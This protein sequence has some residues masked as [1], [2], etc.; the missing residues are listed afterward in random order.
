MKKLIMALAVALTFGFATAGSV[1]Q[2]SVVENEIT[3]INLPFGIKGYSP[4]NKDVVRIEASSDTSLRITALKRGR[5]DLE[6]RGD[7]D[8]V[9]K[10]EIT[11]LGDLATELETLT[12]ELDQVQ[13]VRARIVGNSIRVDGEISSISKW[14]YL[15]KVLRNYGTSVR[16]FVTFLP[17]PEVLLRMKETLQ[18]AGF[19]VV[20]QP[21]GNDRKTWKAK[22][23]ALALNKQTRIMTVQGKVYTPEQRALVLQC[24][25]S[26][27]W[28]SL[29]L[30]ASKALEEGKDEDFRIRG[31]VDVYVDKPQIR[32]SV[33]YMA[34]GEEDV[35]KIGNER[36]LQRDGVLN[37]SG[38]FGTLYSLIHGGTGRH[39]NNTAV[40]GADLGVTANFLKKN[41]ITRI[42]D[43]GYTV[44]ESWSEKGAK[45][46]SGGTLFVRQL[47]IPQ[48]G[49]TS[50]MVMGNLEM[51]EIPY[52]FQ[53]VTK[54]GVT[55]GNMVDMDFNFT[56]SGVSKVD[57]MSGY[58]RKEEVSEQK[59]V[60]ALGKTT[61]ISGFKS[62]VDNRT[63][64][65]GLPILRNTPLL[66][67]FVADSGT[68][69]TD[70][71]LIIMV[72]PEIVDNAQDGNL[73]VEEEINLPVT[74]EGAKTTE[75][76]EKE[77]MEKQYPFGGGLWNPL[78]WFVF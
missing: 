77:K 14:E 69:L 48:G 25:S 3:T 6:V 50:G 34:I 9:Q 60:C 74:V 29:N 13:E 4:S 43:T 20:F 57:D 33:S 59:I 76:R 22:T 46:K 61:L 38:V 49:N 36:A 12:S 10:F 63:S 16:N 65:S 44:M 27:K 30:D 8:L 51:K 1:E 62:L 68:E 55:D 11:V 78:N 39:G 52:G 2:V 56:M 71:R 26:E 66:N 41:G 37:L 35:K 23:I 31:M 32:V 47:E 70:R 42:S 5:C 64:P 18:Q 75:Q 53:I 67:W 28:L 17:G 73:K 15:M 54:G 58:D 24:L 72:C 21:F 19:E 7:K 45:F 40:L